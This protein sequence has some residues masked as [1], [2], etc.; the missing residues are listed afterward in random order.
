MPVASGPPPKPK[1]LVVDDDEAFRHSTARNLAAHGYTD[2]E[3]ASS[4]EARL[5][6]DT[7]PDVAAVLC[8]I[9]MPGASGMELLAELAQDFPDVAV[10]MTTGVDDPDVAAA[11]YGSGAFGYLI[12][13]FDINELLITLDGALT[14][15]DLES[16]QRR[17]IRALELT[18][19]RTRTLR[20]ALQRIGGIGRSALEDDEETIERL[21]RAVS[22]RDEETGRHIQRMSRYSVVVADAIGFTALSSE[23]L[24]LASALH[25]VGKIGVSDSIL[26]KPGSLARDEYAAMQRH[27]QIGFQLLSDATSRLVRIGADIALAHHEW[28][29]GNG[30]PRGL[31]GTEISEEA[32]IAAVTD[33][34]DAITSNRVYRPALSFD[35]GLAIMVELRGRQF[36]PRILDALM[37]SMDEIASIRTAYPDQEDP[38]Q[39]IRVLV[40]DDQEIFR[41]SL[42]RLLGSRAEL[43]V[44]G[45]AGTVADAAAAAVA[46]EP[47][48][49]LM[50]FEL[51]DGDGAEAT[52]RIKVLA[53]SVKVIM[54]T[55]RADEQALV[56]AIESGCSGFVR[57]DE[58]VD[59]L[60][61]AIVAAN[62]GETIAT[63]DELTP[64]LRQLRPTHRG[65]GSDLTPREL[66]VLEL[67]AAGL[68]NKQIAERLGLRLNT[69]RN[70]AQGV[71]AKLQAHSKLE[72][73]A[74]AVREGVIPY[75]TGQQTTRT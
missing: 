54:L 19:A 13:P 23:E 57:K 21:S 59:R 68:V 15:R 7:Q 3:A 9:N 70:H 1:I 69:V 11:A 51:P 49:V 60:L 64:L 39:R 28:W 17:H 61:E 52:E 42:V 35:E 74:T 58:A 66:E 48:V 31:R 62:E 71:L 30:Y 22:L 24:R 14:R 20:G 10:L 37:G 33:V 4:P 73:V 63:P 67:S 41:H 36:E 26:L 34:F 16:E 5:V 50:D 27:A 47:D 6:L 46:L 44:V 65:L 38:Q 56:R 75:P 32:R 25:D 53:P 45:T 43:K 72:A 12:K 18:I 55:V 8:D 29:D 2:V 40:V